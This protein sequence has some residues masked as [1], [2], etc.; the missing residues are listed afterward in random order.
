MEIAPARQS[1]FR[2]GHRV[3]V[4]EEVITAGQM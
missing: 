2:S 3:V 4:I 1:P